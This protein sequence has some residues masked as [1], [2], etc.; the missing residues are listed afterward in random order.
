MAA[1]AKTDDSPAKVKYRYRVTNWAEY[2]L[3]HKSKAKSL[4]SLRMAPTTARAHAAIAEREV[5]AT[6]PPREGAVLWGNDHPR[7]AILAQIETKGRAGWK[8]A[9]G[10]RRAVLPKT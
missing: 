6:I 2:G 9:S 5:R 10:Y 1:K 3:C 4:K 7:D 8:E